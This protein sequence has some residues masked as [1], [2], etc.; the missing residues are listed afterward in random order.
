MGSTE[1]RE[2]PGWTPR[3]TGPGFDLMASKLRRPAPRPGAVSRS[4]LIGQLTRDDSRPIVSVAAP[5]GYGKTTLLSQWAE[6]DGRAIAWVSV[7]ERDNDPK[8][9]L[10]YVAE[11]LDMVEPVG[12]RVF[13]A[14][15]SR[16]S[17]VPG[18]VVPRLGSAFWSMST[19]VMLILDDVHL[20]RNAESRDALSVLADH[21]PPGSRLVLAGRD[22]PPL[23]IARLRAEGRILE[24]GPGDLS[25]SREDATAL[26]RDAGLALA[27]DEIA[28]LHRRTEGWPAGLYLA[29]LY[30]REGGSLGTA[31]VSFGGD[32]RLVSQYMEAE[33]LARISVRH[34]EFLTRTAVLER[35]SGAL[36]EAVLEVPGSAATLAELSRSNL[37]L[38]PLDRR[39]VWYR[40]HHLFRDM[41]LTELERH[42]P[43]LLSMLRG[44]AARWCLENGR[45]E[46]ALGYFMAAEDVDG[47]VR[48]VEQL[49]LPAF[50]QA[51]LTT[52]QRWFAWLDGRDGIEGHPMAAIWGSLLAVQVG[53]PAEAERWAGVVDRWQQR[54]EAGDPGTE[55]W[56]A[57]LRT[58]M[59]PLGVTQMLA[60]ADQ[61]VQRFAAAGIA[62]PIAATCRGIALLLSGDFDGADASLA[63]ATSEG[64]EAGAPDVIATAW[65]ERSLLAIARNDWT[66]AEA[67][68]ARADLVM[69]GAGMEDMLVCAVQA[70]VAL[71]GG[72]VAAAR[73]ELVR[74]QRLRP[75]LTYVQPHLAVQA[76]LE[77]AR[78]QF[79][80][81]DMAGARTLMRE[82]DEI[83][84]RRPDLGTLVGEARAL[85][86][87]LSAEHAP[88][89]PSASSLTAAELRVLPMLAT[90]L[91]FPEIGAE[92][93]LSPHTVKSQAMSIYRKL[94]ASSRNQAVTRS[95]ELGL[96]EG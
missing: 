84:K 35:M 43:G 24:I 38:V 72:D 64:A 77:L 58:L 46:E 20:L 5:P 14:L 63:E 70:R 75:F 68:A 50:R 55:G 33:F 21:V 86:A 22:E 9:L 28:E 82:I 57:V 56:A 67:F 49:A 1:M 66:S 65:C 42:E 81:A 16:V 32:D 73:R 12:E 48:L 71:H 74:A 83:L 94:G 4:S 52:I 39:G 31:A 29:A 91:S 11:A 76:R 17:S 41:L 15:A 60:D 23:R 37:L 26:L 51:R 90:H 8:V 27:E 10:S 47:V 25:L 30:L 62:P 87:R 19:P 13:E 89:A 59:C 80:L 6:H 78:A 85:R 7:D 92:M 79:A 69:R 96:L 36:C 34:R 61:A 45:P 54:G 40:Y 53:R 18:S 95:R 2:R 88:A 44:R 3:A 93:F